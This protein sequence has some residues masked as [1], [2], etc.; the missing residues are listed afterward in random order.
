MSEIQCIGLIG[1][2]FFQVSYLTSVEYLNLTQ[3]RPAMPSG[4]REKYFRG[5]F[6]FSI[7]TKKI[8][9]TLET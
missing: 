9:T 8:T 5:P 1:Q 4:N 6:Q 3:Y 7:V 2:D